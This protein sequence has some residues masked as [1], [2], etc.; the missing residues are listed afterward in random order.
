MRRSFSKLLRDVRGVS[1][2]VSTLLL[3]AIAIAGSGMTYGWV[4]SIA[5]SQGVQ[6]QTQVR[7]EMIEWYMAGNRVKVT[8]RNVG[9]VA[10]T[11]NSVSVKKND[12]G[13]TLIADTDSLPVTIQV[14]E[15]KDVVWNK[16]TTD[17]SASYVIQV[18]CTTGFYYEVADSPGNSS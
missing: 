17:H 3:F 9:S 18:M 6:A 16:G 8:V 13:S 10:A 5:S 7:I 2:I 1:T 14:M 12:A 15:K 11:V 4:I